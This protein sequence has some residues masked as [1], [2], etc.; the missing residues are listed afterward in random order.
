MEIL[1]KLGIK[2]IGDFIVSPDYTHEDF[3]ALEKF[4]KN[5]PIDLPLP[6]I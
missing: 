2:I 5:N 3:E 4:V 6:A 1:N